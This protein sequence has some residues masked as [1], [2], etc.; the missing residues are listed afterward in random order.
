[1][2]VINEIIKIINDISYEIFYF[3]YI[4]T[5]DLVNIISSLIALSISIIALRISKE[6]IRTRCKLG[7]MV[8]KRNN[9]R[10][11][12]LNFGSFITFTNSSHFPVYLHKVRVLYYAKGD[13]KYLENV[14][15]NCKDNVFVTWND[16]IFHNINYFICKITSYAIFKDYLYD[17]EDD[18][19]VKNMTTFRIQYDAIM[20]INTERLKNLLKIE[21]DKSKRIELIK[22]YKDRKR[23]IF[24]VR[25]YLSN[26]K[27]IKMRKYKLIGLSKIVNSRAIM[28]ERKIRKKVWPSVSEE[29]S[30]GAT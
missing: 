8:Y 9:T 1:M 18:F 25:V 30:K 5:S 3:D 13:I 28:R 2:K 7:Y 16:I 19:E 29:L 10:W 27:I 21:K 24:D 15:K 22:K 6:S 26:S 12:Y 23:R 4:E 20:E 17:T 14:K 11:E